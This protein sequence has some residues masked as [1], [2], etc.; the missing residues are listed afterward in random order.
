MNESLV[1]HSEQTPS[2]STGS[3][4][5]THSV[6]SAMSSASFAACDRAPRHALSALRKCVEMERDGGEASASIGGKLALRL[7]TLK[8]EA[9]SPDAVQARRNCGAMRC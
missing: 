4:Q 2:P 8:P 7:E 6:G 5:A 9:R 3:R 1:Q